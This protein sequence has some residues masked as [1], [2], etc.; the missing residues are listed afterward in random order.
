MTTKWNEFPYT[1][2]S[3]PT[4]DY[5]VVNKKYVSSVAESTSLSLENAISSIVVGGAGVDSIAQAGKS[6]ME[7]AIIFSPGSNVSLT[8]TTADLSINIAATGSGSGNPTKVY[9]DA[10]AKISTG[11]TSVKMVFNSAQFSI[12]RAD[13]ASISINLSPS[14][15]VTGTFDASTVIGMFINAQSVTAD[16]IRGSAINELWTTVTNA[17][18]TVTNAYTAIGTISVWIP[19][20]H[21]SATAQAISVGSSVSNAG[22]SNTSTSTSNIW[23]ALGTISTWIPSVHTSATAQAISVGSSV[24]NA[25]S[26]M[27]S[28]SVETLRASLTQHISSG[29]VGHTT[30]DTE[31]GYLTAAVHS[32]SNFLVN[33][34]SRTTD[35]YIVGWN[36]AS[37]SLKYFI[38]G[39][40]L[41]F[42]EDINTLTADGVDEQ[43][44]FGTT[45]ISGSMS[46]SNDLRASVGLFTSITATNAKFATLSISENAYINSLSVSAF[47]APSVSS[48]TEWIPSVSN[49]ASTKAEGF[50]VS[51]FTSATAASS[52]KAEG[53]A[54]SVHTDMTTSVA[55]ATARIG[56]IST[57]LRDSLS[58][59]LSATTEARLIVWSSTTAGVKDF[60]LGSGLYASSGDKSVRVSVAAG[61]ITAS[62]TC[63]TLWASAMLCVSNQIRGSSISITGPAY[64]VSLSASNAFISGTIHAANISVSD[65]LY[66]YSTSADFFR[67]PSASISVGVFSSIYF[68]KS[69][70]SIGL[71][72][73]QAPLWYTSATTHMYAGSSVMIRLSSSAFA[74]FGKAPV[75]Q[76]TVRPTTG[77]STS[78]LAFSSIAHSSVGGTTASTNARFSAISDF[79]GTLADRLCSVG[80]F[81]SN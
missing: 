27:V 48:I 76:A 51:V 46:V 50:G 42:T 56:S 6:G 71:S 1:P 14:L 4:K 58:I 43:P 62:I 77:W 64:F 35:N 65:R 40:H 59:S 53:F 13:T 55:A 75:A 73:E 33:L 15:S 47:Y 9:Q 29:I 41:N 37:A 21:S 28:A 2:A 39:D 78:V 60:A 11:D 61:A 32:M 16:V 57:W 81:R 8:Q 70:V 7:G 12:N 79:L 74:V 25:A 68:P 17:W 22:S 49:A 23:T 19:S 5:Q 24:S 67:G 18:T 36:K 54:T 69:S 72:T 52:T 20:V 45:Y 38:I 31:L 80:I 3:K 10:N 66:A 34:S 30:I 26:A 63:D 44:T